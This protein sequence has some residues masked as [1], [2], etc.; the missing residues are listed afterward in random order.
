MLCF[1]KCEYQFADKQ[2]QNKKEKKKKKKAQ[3][4]IG[5]IFL[6]IIAAG[7]L[8][9]ALEHVSLGNLRQYLRESRVHGGEQGKTSTLTSAQL[10]GLAMDVAKGM[11]YLSDN[12]VSFKRFA[13][14]TLLLQRKR[15]LQYSYWNI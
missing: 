12:G 14:K 9:V 10:I 13:F 2:K 15:R 4:W 3:R 8:Y 1:E 6:I 5:S 7:V 11:Q